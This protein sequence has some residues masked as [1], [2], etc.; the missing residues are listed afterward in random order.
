MQDS[1]S[2]GR[3]AVAGPH[4]RIPSHRRNGDVSAGMIERRFPREIRSLESIVGFVNEFFAARGIGPDQAFDVHLIIEELFT[5][6]VKYSRE[7]HEDIALEL[8]W[9]APDLTIRLRDFGVEPFDVTKPR[10]V[11]VERPVE[12]R[13]RGGLGLRIVREIADR[14]EYRWA[15]R[16]STITVTKRLEV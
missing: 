2:P 14:L 13:R 10:D 12:D 1:S 5:N 11:E 15:D 16:V 4:P 8:G 9:I 6:M 7:S 3:V